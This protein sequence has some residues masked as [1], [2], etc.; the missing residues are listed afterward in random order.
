MF[1]S[2]LIFFTSFLVSMSMLSGL[3][4]SATIITFFL[5]IITLSKR[6][7]KQIVFDLSFFGSFTL[8][9]DKTKSG[10]EYSQQNNSSFFEINFGL[11]FL[12]FCFFSSFWSISPYQT[13]LYSF[14]LL[15]ITSISALI[16][17]NIKYFYDFAPSLIVGLAIGIVIAILFFFIEYYYH[18]IITN[19]VKTT[20]AC[21]NKKNQA[22]RLHFLDK[23]C[24]F[25]SII[26]WSFIFI[27]I[28]KRKFIIA[29][30]FYLIILLLLN[31]SDSTSSFLAFSVTS[32]ALILLFI[33]KKWTNSFLKIVK[34]SIMISVILFL[35]IVKN[36]NIQSV[37]NSNFPLK[38][39]AIHRL[40]IWKVLANKAE[41]NIFLGIG[42]NSSKKL[43]LEDK[44]YYKYDTL[45]IP[46]HPHNVVLQIFLET[47]LIGLSLFLL[48][49][50]QVLDLINQNIIYSKRRIMSYL[51]FCSF[52]NY[53]IISCISFNIWQSFW[54]FS[55]GFIYI[56]I[57]ILQYEP[58]FLQKNASSFILS[59]I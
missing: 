18:G 8:K 44:L 24:A 34:F 5:L 37:I 55:G 14:H 10:I 19:S 47:G 2:S 6:I 13:L 23:G 33:F 28:K 54:L 46:N 1:Y 20:F 25:L 59:E 15:F 45:Y 35:I 22:F 41:E 12:L 51:P 16:S 9:T 3:S 40:F 38:D 39:S 50:Y 7:N 42:M 49:L 30:I 48:F 53:F 52:L 17:K 29:S 26:S 43:E 57:K 32:L 58:V 27:L 36:I 4:L 21:L 11:L 31:I 56:L